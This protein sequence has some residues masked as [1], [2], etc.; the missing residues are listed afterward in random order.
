MTGSSQVSR[1]TY[2]HW[3]TQKVGTRRRGKRR[4]IGRK[5]RKKKRRRREGRRKKN[6]ERHR[7]TETETERLL[8]KD[9]K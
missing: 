9:R 8:I 3:D 5:N 4:K 2:Q 1:D 6:K 7:L